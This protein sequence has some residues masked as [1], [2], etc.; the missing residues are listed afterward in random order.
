MVII[1]GISIAILTLAFVAGLPLALWLSR[2][3]LGE[4]VKRS[5]MILALA[6]IV[7]FALSGISASLSY[8]FFGIDNYPVI[9]FLLALLSWIAFI[10]LRLGSE[11]R[12][13]LK[14][15]S[16]SDAFLLL[17]V[18]LV[19]FLARANWSDMRNP[20]LTTGS[21]PD[22]A[23]NLMAAQ[24]AR[25]LGSTWSEQ[26]SNFLDQIGQSTLRTGV[27]DLFRLPSFRDQ[28]G[29][30]Y[31]VYGTRWGL[32]IPYSQLLR[33]SGERA[34]LWETGIVLVTS[35]MAF[36]VVVFAS[37]KILARSKYT[38]AFT[39]LSVVGNTPFLVQYVNGGLSQAW[40]LVGN[41][42]LFLVIILC[43]RSLFGKH[44][45]NS[46]ALMVLAAAAWICTAVSYVDSAIVI[47]LLI[48]IMT[49]IFF[50]IDRRLSFKFFRLFA[51]SGI[52][53]AALVPVFTF[54]TALTFDFR[55]Q[56][57]TGTGLPSQIWPFPSELVGFVNIFTG[58]TESRSSETLLIAIGITSYI[59]YKFVP[60]LRKRNEDTWISVAG[61][62]VLTI[63]VIG[64]FLSLSGPLGSNY[65]YLKVATY[66]SPILLILFFRVLETS[67]LSRTKDLTSGT[68]LIIPVLLTA[69]ALISVSSAQLVLYKNATTL[70]YEFKTLLEDDALQ[71]ELESHNYLVPY[72][73]SSNLFG[74]MGNVHWISKAPNDIIPGD[75][76]NS[77]LRLICLI[78]DPS[79]KPT[80]PEIQTNLNRYSIKVFQA[81]ITTKQF[82]ALPLI[83]RFNVNFTAFGQPIQEIPER[84]IGGNPYFSRDKRN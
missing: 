39:S 75:R 51:L 4:Y 13:F 80:T 61:I 69:T 24:S 33:F 57:A 52:A 71:E 84:F 1:I 9:L 58:S 40:A 53:A 49:S 5:V 35:L 45:F 59:I 54:V 41:S 27:Y 73:L 28:A 62:G 48:I 72:V 34:I 50:F 21:G 14:G 17:S 66:V 29:V 37:S 19:L 76:I 70:P 60:G 44:P 11:L 25:S 3:L 74:V 47:G 31:L 36:A 7:G 67:K 77:G 56:A 2:S 22:T 18:A 42:G 20:T 38:P 82:F 10:L 23:Q 79:C 55:L 30:D 65:I 15:W 6:L 12:S 26:S 68:T 64:L 32:T 83:E 81:P 8:G 78:Q 63:F 46:R 16:A 43:L